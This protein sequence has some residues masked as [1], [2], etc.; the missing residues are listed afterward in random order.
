MNVTPATVDHVIQRGDDWSFTF[1]IDVDG[2]ILDLTSC[3]VLSQVREGY[4]SSTTLIT[5]F[6]VA[7]NGSNEITL[8]LDETE[9]AGITASIG[10]YDV[11][12][13][14]TN[15]D[16]THY[17]KGSVTFVGTVTIEPVVP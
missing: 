1:D 15:N 5:D 16:Y 17:L 13:I 4:D 2:T 14:D 8:S 12:V 7:V 11:L 6:T 9:T 3:T 10:Y